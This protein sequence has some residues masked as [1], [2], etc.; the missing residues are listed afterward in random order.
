MLGG[1]MANSDC[2]NVMRD[3]KRGFAQ[4]LRWLPRGGVDTDSQQRAGVISTF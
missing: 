1:K 2:V 3:M 4:M